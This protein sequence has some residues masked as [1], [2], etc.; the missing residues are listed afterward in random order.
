MLPSIVGKVLHDQWRGVA[1]WT[2][3][4]GVFAAFYLALY[5]SIGGVAEMR[6]LLDSMPP[7]LRA[8]FAAEGVDIAT[9]AG[10]L[11]IELFTF[12]V[13]LLVFAIGLT[14]AG[15]ATAGEEERGTLELLLANPVRRWRIVL[16]KFVA[17]VITTAALVTGI[18]IALAVTASVF[19]IDLALDRVAAALASAGL[20]GLAIGALAM[21]LG[22]LTGSRTVSIGLALAVAVGGFFLNALGPLV[23]GLKE[24][25][26]LSPHY[27]YIGYDPLANGLDIGHATVLAAIAAVF[28]LV[29]MVAFERRDLRV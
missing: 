27:Q 14:S 5:P 4:S 13:P 26:P 24:W 10:Y 6:R 8:M 29:A 23:E 11:N 22:A 25:R 17:M 18:W 7:A 9:P 20:L 21:T 3:L 2:A 12:I 16:E 19:D 1:A 15:A 28:V